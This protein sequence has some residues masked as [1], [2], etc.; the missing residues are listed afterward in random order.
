MSAAVIQYDAFSGQVRRGETCLAFRHGWKLPSG[1][2]FVY[3]FR[4]SVSMTSAESVAVTTAILNSEP[5]IGG[6]ELSRK[7]QALL[8]HNTN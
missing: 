6:E 7:I 4:G 1:E 3:W 8:C 5:N 2:R